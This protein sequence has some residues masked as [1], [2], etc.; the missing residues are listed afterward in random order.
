MEDEEYINF[1]DYTFRHDFVGVPYNILNKEKYEFSS[2][3]ENK[4]KDVLDCIYHDS[5]IRDIIRDYG[6][7]C[8]TYV[9]LFDS[10]DVPPAVILY[11]CSPDSIRPVVVINVSDDTYWLD[12]DFMTSVEA[13]KLGYLLQKMQSYVGESNGS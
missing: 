7:D 8:K 2:M 5:L 6:I 12:L 11:K 13:S 10:E 4:F 1:Y 9:R 3:S